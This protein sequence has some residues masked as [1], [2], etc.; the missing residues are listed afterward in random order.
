MAHNFRK[1]LVLPL[2]VAVLSVGFAFAN[3]GKAA[4][5]HEDTSK[6]IVGAWE[7]TADAPYPPHLFTFNADGTMSTTNPTNVQ[8]NPSAAHGGTN[9]SV[10]MGAWKTVKQHGTT[11]IVGTFEELNAF[12]DNHQPTDT[13]S[14]SF[15]I[16]V[17]GNVLDGPAQ[18]KIGTFTVPSHLHGTRIVVDQAA[19]D[20]L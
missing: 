1:L 3:N 8:E 7:V 16:T 6:A 15:K 2:L 11:Y 18:A 10:G 19:V 5:G 12:A 9:D 20:S 17:T 14:V 13:L 4:A